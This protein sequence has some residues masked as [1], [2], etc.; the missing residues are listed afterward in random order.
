MGQ[1]RALRGA[2]ASSAWP[3]QPEDE[4]GR[5]NPVFVLP[6]LIS[7]KRSW[8]LRIRSWFCLA[9]EARRGAGTCEPRT[10]LWSAQLALPGFLRVLGPP[11][12]RTACA[13]LEHWST[14]IGSNAQW[15][16]P[17]RKGNGASGSS[18]GPRKRREF[19]SV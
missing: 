6:G 1:A 12:A 15:S 13:T 18:K 8:D 9:R 7:Q 14:M 11:V 17:I 5:E 2:L 19:G 3:G 16:R 10:W 4:L